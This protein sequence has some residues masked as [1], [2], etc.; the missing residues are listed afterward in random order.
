MS[1]TAVT[2]LRD[3]DHH[4]SVLKLLF[5]EDLRAVMNITASSARRSYTVNP[6]M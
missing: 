1:V 2:C 6:T 5:A 3:R 4:R